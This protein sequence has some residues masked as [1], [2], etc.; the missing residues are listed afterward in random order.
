MREHTPGPREPSI[1]GEWV[2]EMQR[3]GQPPYSIRLTLAR[4]GD[5][6]DGLVRYPTG[7][8]PIIDGHF[9]AGILTFRTEHIPQF[10]SEPA[11]V[12]FHAKLLGDTIELTLMNNAGTATG[13]ARRAAAATGERAA[14]RVA[15][16]TLPSLAYGT[17][18]LRNAR[19]EQGKIWS[20][21]VL[22]FTSQDEAPDGLLLRG[23][24]TWRLDNVLMGTEEFTGHYVE[25]TRQ[26]IL[27]GRHGVRCCP[28]WPRAPG[29]GV[30]FRGPGARR[31]NARAGAMGIDRAE[32]PRFRRRVGSRTLSV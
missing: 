23:R 2:A 5:R 10:E 8:G 18:T 21:S 11:T 20:N 25:R 15:S 16:R 22:Q 12:R 32:R 4:A 6:L 3:A 13:I 28:Q 26:V 19:D 17:W 31:A 30:V 7:D 1:D 27:E 14:N 29:R 9:E 24:F